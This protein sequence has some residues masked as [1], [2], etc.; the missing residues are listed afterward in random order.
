[1]LIL[2]CVPHLKATKFLFSVILIQEIYE[3]Y[4]IGLNY[5]VQIKHT[6][7]QEEQI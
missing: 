5:S 6:D 4:N 1:M 2:R 7:I 3:D